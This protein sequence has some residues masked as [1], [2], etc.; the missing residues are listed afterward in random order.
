MWFQG[1]CF[2]VLF[3]N[4]NLKIKAP[5][6]IERPLMRERAINQYDLRS[7]TYNLQGIQQDQ[8]ATLYSQMKLETW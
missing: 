8:I 2:D 4:A 1:T 5:F 7:T 3:L 6:L